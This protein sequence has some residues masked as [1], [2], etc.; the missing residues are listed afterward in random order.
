MFVHTAILNWILNWISAFLHPKKRALT[1]TST[2]ITFAWLDLILLQY[3]SFLQQNISVQL[4]QPQVTI[5][6]RLFTF[7]EHKALAATPLMA[8]SELHYHRPP[9]RQSD[10]FPVLLH[11]YW[12]FLPLVS[13]W[14][15]WQSSSITAIVILSSSCAVAA[16]IIIVEKHIGKYR[17]M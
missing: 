13:G 6:E 14:W 8:P 17:W 15:H 10:S 9:P 5:K 2:H 12:L 1:H 7:L 3:L 16:I 11:K 4:T